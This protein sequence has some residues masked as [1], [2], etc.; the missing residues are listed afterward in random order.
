MEKALF[1]LSGRTALVTGGGS[2]LGRSIAEAFAEYGADIAV[3]S[4][5]VENCQETADWIKKTYGVKAKAYLCD[6]SSEEQ[7]TQTVERV[8]QD[9]GKIDILVN[10]SGATW[11]EYV[12]DMPHRC[13]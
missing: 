6:V 7:I 2:G 9:F 8:L 13:Y 1:D 10:N 12:Q 5:K 3:C 4:R 11:G